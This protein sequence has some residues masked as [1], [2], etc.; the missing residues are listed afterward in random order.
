MAGSETRW[1]IDLTAPVADRRLAP[2][3]LTE[4][5]VAGV[6][7]PDRATSDL[8]AVAMV[9][10][11]DHGFE[12]HHELFLLQ[13]RAPI[14][15][16]ST[17][18]MRSFPSGEDYCWQV[19][20]CVMSNAR[21]TFTFANLLLSYDA[22]REVRVRRGTLSSGDDYLVQREHLE[23]SAMADSGNGG[24]MQEYRLSVIVEDGAGSKRLTATWFELDAGTPIE[25]AVLINVA[26]NGLADQH[27]AED[28]FLSAL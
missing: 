1:A 22:V 24:M 19:D 21:D 4:G 5:N 18:H 16:S 8:L 6:D 17:V 10:A 3:L 26:G 14:N 7:H 25:E 2:P 15:P 20:E 9:S 28:D 12:A 27:E 23:V 11:S 13:D